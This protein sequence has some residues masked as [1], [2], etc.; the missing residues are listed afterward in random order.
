MKYATDPI[1]GANKTAINQ[2][3]LLLPLNSLFRIS[4]NAKMNGIKPKRKNNINNS[5]NPI[6]YLT[7][8]D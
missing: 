8:K 2:I 5:I 6:I 1:N 7:V 4:M 3:N